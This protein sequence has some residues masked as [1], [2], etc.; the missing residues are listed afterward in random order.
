[1]AQRSGS[2]LQT[3]GIDRRVFLRRSVATGLASGVGLNGTVAGVLAASCGIDDSTASYSEIDY[4]W[5]DEDSVTEE[6]VPSGSDREYAIETQSSAIH[7]S[8]NYVTSDDRWT[9]YFYEGAHVVTQRKASYESDSA[10]EPYENVNNHKLTIDNKDPDR[11][12]LFVTDNS[13]DVGAVP[14]PNDSTDSGFGDAAWTAIKFALTAESQKLSIASTAADVVYHLLNNGESDSGDLQEYAWPYGSPFPCEAAHYC[15]FII[16]GH[17]DY[18]KANV[19]LYEYSVADAGNV[20]NS[21]TW[22]LRVDPYDGGIQ[23]IDGISETTSTPQPGTDEYESMLEASDQF[24]KIPAD[25]VED[26]SLRALADGEPVYRAVNPDVTVEFEPTA[27][28][29]HSP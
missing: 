4:E 9:H 17:D 24:V 7:A 12:S 19:N 18:A 23:S 10:Y 8:S 2:K 20:N 11:T 15:H 6:N 21:M 29:E 14:S 28:E 5:K 16:R 3:F 22:E 1:M 13:Y 26:P 25:A 27:P